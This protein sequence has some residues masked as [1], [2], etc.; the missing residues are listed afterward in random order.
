[1]EIKLILSTAW[2]ERLK[3]S[4]KDFAQLFDLG[5]DRARPA[6]DSF[7]CPTCDNDPRDNN[8][9]FFDYLPFRSPDVAEGKRFV[10]CVCETVYY[11][12]TRK[13]TIYPERKMS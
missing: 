9:E 8:F 10:G 4:D 13:Q 12:G 1:M 5:L 3:F 7:R 11:L 2:A 6:N